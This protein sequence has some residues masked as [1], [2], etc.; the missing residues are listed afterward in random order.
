M[1]FMYYAAPGVGKGVH[2][3]IAC[4]KLSSFLIKRCTQLTIMCI[5]PAGV[6][7]STFKFLDGFKNIQES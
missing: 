2:K 1:L 6:K 4:K 5:M 7:G 3:Q